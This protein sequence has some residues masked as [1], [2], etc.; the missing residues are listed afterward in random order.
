MADP[1]QVPVTVDKQP[2]VEPM[3]RRVSHFAR[4]RIAYSRAFAM[5]VLATLLVAQNRWYDAAP[6]I[7]HLLSFT[8]WVL[9]AAGMTGRVWA[10]SYVCGHK[11]RELMTFGP[12]SMCRNPLYLFSFVAGL[13]VMFATETLLFPVLFAALFAAAYPRV[14]RHEEATL[15]A[16]H[17]AAFEE[18]RSRVPLF[19]P[20]P[21]LYA[22]PPSYLVVARPFRRHLADAPWWVIA[23]AIFEV[24]EGLHLSGHLPTLARVF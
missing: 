1:T 19:W 6:T 23:G 7:E 17:G 13:G 15:R 21:G 22:E 3:P 16:V 8:G 4:H 10:A 11:D 9:I 20:K 12:Y 18:Y 2:S 5:T 14:M 24:I